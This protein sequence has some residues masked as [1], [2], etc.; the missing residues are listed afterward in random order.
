MEELEFIEIRRRK[1]GNRGAIEEIAGGD[2][3]SVDQ[4]TV[5]ARHAK[6]VVRNIG[7]EG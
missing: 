2:K 5:G 4:Q 7:A 6:I 3:R 1:P